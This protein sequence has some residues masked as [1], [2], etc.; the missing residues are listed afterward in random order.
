MKKFLLLAFLLLFMLGVQAQV[1]STECITEVQQVYKQIDHQVLLSQDAAMLLE[2]HHSY[3][4]RSDPKGEKIEGD[5]WRLYARNFLHHN[6]R[7]FE[8]CTDAKEAFNYRKYQYVVYRTKNTLDKAGLVPGMDAGL[9]A[10]ATVRRCKFVPAPGQDSISYKLAFLTVDETGQKSYKI[11]DMEMVWN[12]V[13]G[14]MVSLTVNFTARSRTQW[15]KYVFQNIGP[16]NA[17]S[18]SPLHAAEV[19]LDANGSLKGKYEGA[20]LKDYR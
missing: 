16:A 8:A 10:H 4:M 1:A 20:D 11:T 9:F 3:I 12:P 2:Y 13:S 18:A 17:E 19:F 5:E 6:G 14:A 15:A 7:E